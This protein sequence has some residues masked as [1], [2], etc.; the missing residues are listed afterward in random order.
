MKKIKICFRFCRCGK[1]FQ[2]ETR[3]CHVCDE[4]KKEVAKER[5]ERVINYYKNK[6]QQDEKNKS[7]T[8]RTEK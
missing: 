5:V 8:K 3:R 2:P 4:C 6:K 7:T 1:K